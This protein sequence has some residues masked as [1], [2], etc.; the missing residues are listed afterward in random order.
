M[1]KSNK[2]DINQLLIKGYRKGV[3]SAI[4]TACKTNT[5]L[6]VEKN[7]KIVTIK[8][9]YKYVKVLKKSVQNKSTTSSKK[10]AKI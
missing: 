10:K 4:E 9:K 1:S 6:I 3:K 2:S 5:A 8:P 7:D